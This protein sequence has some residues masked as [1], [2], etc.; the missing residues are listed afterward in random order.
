MVLLTDS[1]YGSAVSYDFTHL[2]EEIKNYGNIKNRLDY[3][4]GK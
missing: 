1:E 3:L 2:P 4:N